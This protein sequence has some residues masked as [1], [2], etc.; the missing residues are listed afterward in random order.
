MKFNAKLGG[1][2]TRAIGA[3]NHPQFG[4]FTKPTLIIGA[5]VSHAAPGATDIPSMACMTFSTNLMCTRY[6][7]AVETN[8]HRVEMIKRS[9]IENFMKPLI[10]L[11]SSNLGN[12]KL[13][14]QLIYFRDGKLP[15]T[16]NTLSMKLKLAIGVSEGQYQ[17][18]LESEVNDIK[19]VLKEFDPRQPTKITVLV[20]T[21]RH[22][23]R[24][25]PDKN[26]RNAA[27]RNGNALPGTL[28]QTGCTTPFEYDFYLCAHSAIKVCLV[29]L[30]VHFKC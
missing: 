10:T 24:F 8:G 16:S 1:F 25:F 13:P 12:G 29:L 3:K 11:W 23:I 18:V 21:K 17:Q 15:Q 9:N 30:N 5:D 28:V 20:A 19:A 26:D 6:A 7:A 4:S 22:H 27:D 14:E 2:T